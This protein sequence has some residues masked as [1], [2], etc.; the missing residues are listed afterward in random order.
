[1]SRRMKPCG[2]PGG[3]GG[4]I[5][6][7]KAPNGGWMKLEPYPDPQGEYRVD[8]LDDA[9]VVL[10]DGEPSSARTKRYERHRCVPAAKAAPRA[11]RPTQL[12]LTESGEPP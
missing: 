9:L 5:V 8:V 2:G 1:M 12:A 11:G 7:A 10:A 4:G 3:C 6:K